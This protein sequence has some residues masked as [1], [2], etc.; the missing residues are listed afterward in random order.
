MLTDIILVIGAAC[1]AGAIVLTID[2]LRCLLSERGGER[3]K[4]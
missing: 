3:G 4:P 2:G 1:M